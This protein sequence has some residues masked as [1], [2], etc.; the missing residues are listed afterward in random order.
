MGGK[1]FKR[2]NFFID[3]KAIKQADSLLKVL[4]HPL[5]HRIISLIKKN[6]GLSSSQVISTL[7]MESKL[8][9]EQKTSE[10]I[11]GQLTLSRRTIEDYRGG[12]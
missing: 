9:C 6:G 2:G 11:A 12:I 5:R 1:E 3:N 8:V 7:G 10:E 4:L